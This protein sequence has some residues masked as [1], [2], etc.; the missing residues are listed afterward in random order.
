MAQPS[1][2][3]VAD[4]RLNQILVVSSPADYTYIASLISEFD[5]PLTVAEPYERGSSTPRPSMC[6]APWSIFCRR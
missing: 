5:K 4:T 1:A 2:Q 6:S 3:V